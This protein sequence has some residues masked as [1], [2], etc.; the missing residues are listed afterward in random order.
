MR[1]LEGV[2]PGDG[3]PLGFFLK[4]DR[5]LVDVLCR[6]IRC[7]INYDLIEVTTVLH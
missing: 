5:Q 7:E 2:N 1:G 3:Y 6:S 4:A